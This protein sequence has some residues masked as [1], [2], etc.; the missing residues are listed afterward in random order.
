MRLG[1]I[2]ALVLSFTSGLRAG[3]EQPAIQA[4][5]ITGGCCHDYAYQA[6]RLVEGSKAR[7]HIE[8]TVALD[9]RRG[10]KGKIDLYEDPNWAAPY[11]VVVHNECFASTADPEYVRKITKAHKDGVASVVIH[12][13]MHTYR[14]A[15]IDDWR[16]MLG[17]TS[18][19]HEHQ[20]RYPITPVAKDHPVMAGFPETWT[21]PKDELYV[22][23]KLW[24]NTTVLATGKSERGG[25]EH[26]AF[27]V[28]TYG[29][30]RVFGTTFGHGSATFDDKVFIDTVTRG[31]LWT[32]ET[33]TADGKPR[34][35]YEARKAPAMDWTRG[36][37]ARLPKTEKAVNLFNGKDLAGWTGAK[38]I[39]SVTDGTIIGRNVKPVKTS[40]YLFTEKSY[41]EFRLLFEV[42]QTRSSQ[43][44]PMHSAV[45]ALGERFD[46][47]GNAFGFKGPLLMFC[48][49]WGI[50]DAYRRN[51]TEPKGHKGYFNPKGVERVGKW[52]EI[53]ILVKG[54]R[55]RFVAN[56]K[57]VFDMTD[58][59]EMLST[60]PI[61]L[62]IHSGNR[63]QEFRFR[64]LVLTEGP[65]D[66]LITLR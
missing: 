27:W 2:A 22:I 11:D 59:P 31:I 16:E 8:W 51:R 53:E 32:T 12:C 46:D 33:I 19:R 57:L 43:H 60:S 4:L 25:K 14:S 38:K 34:P 15:K 21:S 49:D 41:R 64:G 61:G 63:P 54:N 42:R 28:S 6:K 5:L 35:G 7:A 23:E 3:E 13:A 66:K 24:P 56:G 48:N 44:S 26:A 30:G 37:I 47:K 17:V 20:S 39:W 1:L 55:V 45:A 36:Q 65:E 29:K 10:T 58:K 9:P 40:T 52:N 18:R 62:Q 50:W